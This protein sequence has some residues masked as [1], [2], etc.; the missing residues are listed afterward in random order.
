[1]RATLIS[2]FKLFLALFL[3]YS[4]VVSVYLSFFKNQHFNFLTVSFA[5]TLVSLFLFS[6]RQLY[7][8]DLT[9]FMNGLKKIKENSKS[10]VLLA[11]C[12]LNL[13]ISFFS[14][15]SQY[16]RT[17]MDSE[18]YQSFAV[19]RSNNALQE[20]WKQQQPPLDYYFSSFANE[21]WGQSKFAIRFHAMLFY[22]VLSLILPLLLFFFCPSL[23]AVGLGSFLFSINHVIRLHSVNG[24]PISLA[25]LTGFLFLFFYMFYCKEGSSDKQNNSLFPVIASQYLFVMSIGFQPVI[26]I[27]SLFVSSFCLLFQNKKEVFKKLFLSHVITALLSLPVYIKMYFFGQDTSKFR[28]LSFEGLSLYIENWNMLNLF[29]G[30]FYP[31]Y[32][33]LSLFLALLFCAWIVVI[34]IQKR[35][36]SLTVQI[37]VALAV[38]PLIFD[39]LFKVIINW[40][41]HNWYF[42]I[43]SLLLIFFPVL[44]LGEFFQ[45]LNGKNWKKYLFL[46]PAVFLF[47]GNSFFQILAIKQKSQFW[48]PYRGPDIK[49]A[50]DYLKERGGPKDILIEISLVQPAGYQE[51]P[52][53]NLSF[54]FY[55]KKA[56]PIRNNYSVTTAQSPPFFYEQTDTDVYYIQWEQMPKNENQK[57]FF[58]AINYRKGEDEASFFLSRL[59]EEKRIGRI[60]IFEWTLPKTKNREKEYKNFLSSLL[61]Q[62]Y[63]KYRAS[64]YETLLYYACKNKNKIRLTQLL[65]EYRGLEPFLDKP[66]VDVNPFY[67]FELKRRAKLFQSTD[68]CKD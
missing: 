27:I 10:P 53:N 3:L 29:K 28:K 22:L 65:K 57:I 66:R 58:T 38:F 34:F 20:S 8:I 24:R 47:I 45:Y 14:V 31:F 60:S 43:W 15:Y 19:F 64:L 44:I 50:Y 41:V 4:S 17:P 54:F 63:P 26:L 36:P 21:L 1:M 16:P 62:T 6:V 61:E 12:L 13:I 35:I 56:H 5:L 46:I 55:D 33:Q 68:F 7:Q 39:F 32:E 67:R 23:W 42:V 52:F 51:D 37:S 30:Y 49:L 40:S 48:H 2:F 18:I 11:L 25:L 59:L 9:V